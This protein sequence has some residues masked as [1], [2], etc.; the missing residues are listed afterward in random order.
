MIILIIFGI[1]IAIAI[2][3]IKGIKN[4]QEMKQVQAKRQALIDAIIAEHK[5][6]STEILL[7]RR[8]EVMSAY[9]SLKDR[10]AKGERF[11][12]DVIFLP[13]GDEMLCSVDL[14]LC[15]VILKHLNDE[16][17]QRQK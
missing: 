6:L 17:A 14:D 10:V 13:I 9:N 15:S 4:C 3:S 5:K 7:N 16:I 11:A 8:Q 12:K 1:A 2:I